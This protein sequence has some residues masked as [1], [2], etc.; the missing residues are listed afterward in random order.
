[1]S[2]ENQGVFQLLKEVTFR[3][4]LAFY[5][6]RK[7]G[8]FRWC[9]GFGYLQ[10]L[11]VSQGVE[12]P[13]YLVQVQEPDLRC[14]L[15]VLGHLRYRVDIARHLYT[16]FIDSPVEQAVDDLPVKS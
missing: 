7:W 12:L 1:V 14:V 8:H 6:S 11:V 4:I 3:R 10:Q 2:P 5:S 13:L 9:L 16:L 15:S